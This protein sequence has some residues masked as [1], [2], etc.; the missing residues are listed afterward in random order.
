MRAFQRTIELFS[1][2]KTRFTVFLRAQAPHGERSAFLLKADGDRPRHHLHRPG[3][4]R[5]G[6]A[7]PVACPHD[8][9]V[10]SYYPVPRPAD[11]VEHPG[12]DRAVGGGEQH[13]E[14]VEPVAPNVAPVAFMA[15]DEKLRGGAL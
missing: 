6:R 1:R 2:L 3:E 14:P 9:L 5:Q 15:S 7:A 10:R 13:R 4:R 11:L 8:I 12:D